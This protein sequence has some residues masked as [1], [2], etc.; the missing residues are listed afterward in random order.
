[1]DE[2]RYIEETTISIR[3]QFALE[4]TS[5]IQTTDERAKYEQLKKILI[6]RLEEMIDHE[7]EKFINVLYRIDVSEYKVK[8]ALTE[9]PFKA[10]VEKIAEMIIQ[11]QM[12]KVITR[13]Q[14]ATQQHDLEFDV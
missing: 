8:K 1:M 6:K 9:Q 12:Q 7:F 10:G 4:N 14:Y 3:N 11:R 2:I 5:G 13:K